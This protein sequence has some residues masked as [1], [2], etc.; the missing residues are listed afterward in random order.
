M[1]RV[2]RMMAEDAA[3]NAEIDGV[4]SEINAIPLVPQVD[5]SLFEKGEFAL[6]SAHISG[7]SPDRRALLEREWK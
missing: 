6:A 3:F 1:T 5:M 2:E 7:L 4:I